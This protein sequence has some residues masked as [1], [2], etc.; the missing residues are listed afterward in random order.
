MEGIHGQS[1][2]VALHYE[3]VDALAPQAAVLRRQHDERVCLGCVGYE[4]LGAVKKIRPVF[5]RRGR[6]QGRGVAARAGLRQTERA[7][8]LALCKRRYELALLAPG[9]EHVNELHA[10]GQ[11][12]DIRHA[13]G[14]ARPRYLL[15]HENE[16]SGRTAAAAV[17]L[18]NRKAQQAHVGEALEVVPGELRVLVEVRGP[19]S[20]LLVCEVPNG[21]LEQLLLFT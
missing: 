14:G 20:Q 2:G 10:Q 7:H 18:V 1:G 8:V 6:S 11:V 17:L 9:A 13:G 19:R 12:R 15:H 16:L 5:S 21:V 4:G 3:R